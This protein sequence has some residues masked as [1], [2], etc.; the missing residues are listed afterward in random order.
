MAAALLVVGLLVGAGLTYALTSSSSS[1]K[2]S[3]LSGTITIG[4]LTDLSGA[5]SAI[6]TQQ[7][8]AVDLAVTDINTYLTQSGVT[9]VKFAAND[10]DTGLVPAKALTDLQSLYSSGVQVVVGPLTSSEASTVLQTANQDHVVLIS[11]SSTAIS[12]AIPNDYLF[13]LVPNDAAQSL[14]IAR[15][16]VSQNVKDIILIAQNSVYG[17]GLANATANRFTALGGNIQDK[18]LYSTTVTDFTPTLTTAQSDYTAAVAKYGASS[19][20][21]V[22]IGFQEVG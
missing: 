19:V 21:I 1:S 18:L 10:Q 15:E 5:L 4:D 16:L 11:A 22:A 17:A 12:L 14:A 3:G 2:A 13:R 8:T 20:A 7:K 6:G 9:N